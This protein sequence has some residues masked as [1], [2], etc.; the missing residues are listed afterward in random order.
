M[1]V[2]KLRPKTTVGILSPSGPRCSSRSVLTLPMI[3]LVSSATASSTSSLTAVLSVMSMWAQ[4]R[5]AKAGEQVIL[6]APV[7]VPARPISDT[8]PSF[9]VGRAVLDRDFAL[10]DLDPQ[11]GREDVGA[12]VADAFDNQFL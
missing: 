8:T 4:M 9:G 5:Q 12:G 2:L 3:I 6:P 11:H 1:R 7:Q 10:P